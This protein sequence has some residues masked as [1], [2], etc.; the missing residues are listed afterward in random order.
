V[1]TGLVYRTGATESSVFGITSKLDLEHALREQR[2]ESLLP[3]LWAMIFRSGGMTYEALR[4]QFP[5]ED[6][7]LA[8]ALRE[9]EAEG[10]VQKS[11][12]GEQALY[13]ASTFL[14]PVGAQ[15]G[16]EAA[17]FDHFQ[18]VVRAIGAKVQRGLARSESDDVVGGATLTFD[19]S[20]DHPHKDEVLGLLK[21]VR[22]EVNELWNRVQAR[23]ERHPIPDAERMEVSFYFGQ[24]LTTTDHE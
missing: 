24:S 3:I 7:S 5:A 2:R 16:W 8:E 22:V 15:R 4:E 12:E 6:A 18:A 13:R 11:G 20:A 19:V 9:L 23:N 21:Q 1:S 10:H 17:V 14:V